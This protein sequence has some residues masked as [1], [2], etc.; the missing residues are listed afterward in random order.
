MDN[1]YALMDL[2]VYGR[3]EAW[4]DSPPAWPQGCTN[5]RTDG[6]PPAWP[7]VPE[8]SAG[9]PIPQWPRLEAGHSDDLTAGP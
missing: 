3:Q 8:W 7:P 9:R 6:G 5:T 2:T 1:S 4:E